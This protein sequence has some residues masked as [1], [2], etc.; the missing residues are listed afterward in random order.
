MG[1]YFQIDIP[2]MYSEL[3][4]M[5]AELYASVNVQFFGPVATT[6]IDSKENL[7]QEYITNIKQTIKNRKNMINKGKS[8]LNEKVKDMKQN[9]SKVVINGTRSGSGRIVYEHY[10]KL[11]SIWDGSVNTKFI[12]VMIIMLIVKIIVLWR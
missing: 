9:D 1:F 11:V 10:N 2:I 5:M 6:I 12:T 3:K 4:K 8:R 7:W